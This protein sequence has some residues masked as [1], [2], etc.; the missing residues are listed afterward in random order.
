MSDAIGSVGFLLLLGAFGLNAAGKMDRS[1]TAYDI[2]NIVGAGILGWYAI[3]HAAPVFVVLEAT[4]VAIAVTALSA[5][6]KRS[7]SRLPGR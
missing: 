1:S 3:T 4:W 2:L 7:R 6:V 5:K